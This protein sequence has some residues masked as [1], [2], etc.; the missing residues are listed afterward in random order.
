[1]INILFID[2]HPVVQKGFKCFFKDQTN[3]R[4]YKTI[5]SIDEL[6]QLSLSLNKIDII[7]SEIEIK[8]GNIQDLLKIINKKIPIII[9]TSKPYSNNLSKLLK[10]GVSDYILKS[11]KKDLITNSI[12]KVYNKSIGTKFINLNY[13]KL[14]KNKVNLSKREI[15]VLRY[16]IDGKRNVEISKILKINQKTVN[17]YKTRVFN[18]TKSINTIELY[19]YANESKLF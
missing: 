8:D 6:S 3:M 11:S 12:E 14:N 13:L 10:M 1:M 18:K 17:T 9:F 7:V 15:Q 19:K 2:P 4:V 16:L 5:R